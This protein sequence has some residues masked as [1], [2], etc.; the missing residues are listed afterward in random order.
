MNP[1][2]A[3]KQGRPLHAANS[4]VPRFTEWDPKFH[5]DLSMMRVV[6]SKH[7]HYRSEDY[8]SRQCHEY[9]PGQHN[10]DSEFPAKFFTLPIAAN[11]GVSHVFNVECNRRADKNEGRHEEEEK[12]DAHEAASALFV[13]GHTKEG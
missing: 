8:N 6:G 13:P 10:W 9:Y 12:D 2:V 7:S 5:I 4:M 11:C 1:H 3:S